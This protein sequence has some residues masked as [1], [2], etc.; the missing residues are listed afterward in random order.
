MSTLRRPTSRGCMGKFGGGGE[1]AGGGGERRVCVL[2][3]RIAVV[4]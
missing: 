3:S 1:A 2:I 4:L